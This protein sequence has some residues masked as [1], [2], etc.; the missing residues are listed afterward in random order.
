M[1]SEGVAIVGLTGRFPGARTLEE[2]WANLRDGVESITHFS[3]EELAR[4]G[5]DPLLLDRPEYVKSKGVLA[6]IDLF[7]ARFFGFPP[8]EAEITDPQHRIFLE[9][10]WEALEQ[11]GYDPSCH[12]GVT[13]VY[14]GAGVNTYLL[15]SLLSGGAGTD[16]AHAF[17][18][19]IHNKADHL[20]TRVAYK[21]N[22]TGP[23]I[24]VQTACS[25]SLVA[26]A[27]ACQSLLT[28]QCDT[29]LAGGVCINVPQTRGYLYQEGGVASPDG[30]C[31]A[32]DE[33]AKGVVDGSGAGVVVLK[34]L[35]DALAAGDHIHAVIRGVAIN[36]DG[37]HKQG[38]TA[39]GLESQ[40]E[41]IAMAQAM[42]EVDPADI[43]YVEAHGTGT[44]LG[45]PIEIAA[46]IQAFSRS[47]AV[48]SGRCAVGSVKTNIGHLDAAAGVA[49]LI[50]TILALQKGAI[51]PTLH[52][53]RPNPL[54][55]FENSPFYVSSRLVPWNGDSAPRRA[56]VSSFG[57]GG[58][59]AHVVVEESPTPVP[60][61][62]GPDWHLLPI[63]A[64]TESALEKAAENLAAY[65]ARSTAPMADVAYT[66][67][68]G[69]TPHPYR[70]IVVCGDA[71]DAISALETLAPERVAS[72]HQEKIHR[73]IV[74]LFPGQGAQYPK[75]AAGLFL[76]QAAF[77]RELDRCSEMFEP[78]L[79]VRLRDLIFSSAPESL[80]RTDL[81]QP[82]LFAVAYSIANFWIHLGLKP[83]AMLGHSI[84]EYVA[85]CLSGVFT[86]EDAAAA[87]AFRGRVM[88]ATPEGAMLAVSLP[89]R[90]L[91]PM[92]TGA[93]SLAAI[94][95]ASQ[96]VVSG[97]L[98]AVA[99]LE[100][101]LSAARI[102][103]RR[104]SAAR[105]FHSS[106]TDTAADELGRR[107]ENV[108]L[109][110]PVIPFVSSL[111]GTWITAD[112]AVSPEYWARHLRHTVRFADGLNKILELPDALLIEAG[113]GATLKT[114]A[115]W[116]PSKTP[117]QIVITSLP[118][119]EA[120]GPD[121]PHFLR[122]VGE[123][124]LAG[125][126]VRWQALHDG[127]TRRRVPLPTYPFERRRYWID[128][129]VAALSVANGSRDLRNCFYV[130]VWKRS[131]RKVATISQAGRRWMVF[132]NGGFGD[133]IIRV[134]RNRGAQV[135]AIA[136]GDDWRPLL[137]AGDSDPEFMIHAWTND[138][139]PERAIDLG[140]HALLSFAQS[141]GTLRRSSRPLSITIVSSELFAVTRADRV[142][143]EKSTLLGPAKVIPLEY[144]N[145]RCRVIDVGSSQTASIIDAVI[146]ETA[147]PGTDAAVAWRAGERWT[148][149]FEAVAMDRVAAPPPL[150]KRQGVYLITGGFGGVGSEIAQYLARTCQARLVLLGRSYDVRHDS[151][152]A[153]VRRLEALGSEVL[154]LRADVA[155][156]ESMTRAFETT[157]LRFGS[158]DGVF[159]LAGVA[160][161]GMI[162]FRDAEAVSR[163]LT[164][165]IAGT[166]VIERLISLHGC[167]FLV[168]ASSLA[169]VAGRP[170]QVDYCA[171][172]A[173]LD[174]FAREHASQTGIHTVA[175][176]WCEWLGVGMA[177]R[178][179]F[180]VAPP[181][182]GADHPLLGARRIRP[183]GAEIYT[184]RFRVDTHW[185][186]DE[187]RLVGMAVIP[188]TSYI[189]MARAALADR[190]GGRCI[191]I[192][193]LYFLAPLHVRNHESREVR[194]CLSPAADGY[195]FFVESDA[196]APDSDGISV[197]YASGSA[198]I[199]DI[200]P[201]GNIDL[202]ELM[203]RCPRREVPRDEDR[204]EDLGPRWQNVVASY[205]GRDEVLVQLELAEAFAGD[206]DRIHYH[207]ALMD[208]ATGRA[209]EHLVEGAFLPISYRRIRIFRPT[210]SRIFSHAQYLRDRDPSGE[211][212]NYDTLVVDEAGCPLVEIQGFTQKRINQAGPA[213]KAF[214]SRRTERTVNSAP[215]TLA[216]ADYTMSA[217]E[218][219]ET[220]ERILAS[221]IGPQV[222]VSMQPLHAE[223]YPPAAAVQQRVLGAAIRARPAQLHPRPELETPFVEPQTDL[224][225]T[226]AVAW[227]E[228]LG[229]KSIGAHDN[230]FALGGDSVQAIQIIALL[231]RGGLRVSPQQ[232][233]Q[234]QTIAALGAALDGD[235]TIEPPILIEMPGPAD[236]SPLVD[237][238]QNELERLSALIDEADREQS[239]ATPPV[240]SSR[241]IASRPLAFSL[242]YFADEHPAAAGAKYRLYLEGAQFADR[243]GFEAVWTPERH[244]HSKGGLYPNPSVL[245]AALAATT[246]QIQLRAGSVVLP[247][248]SA[249]RVAEEWA[250]V[251]NLSS[252]RAGLSVA[253]GWQPNDF[254]FFPGHYRDKRD[255]M[256]RGIADLQRL[257]RGESIPGQDGAGREI[258]VRVFPRPIQKELPLWLTCSGD[259]EMFRI[260]GQMGLNVLTAML[261]HSLEEAA[262]KI[263]LYRTARASSGHD[264]EAGVVTMMIHTFVGAGEKAVLDLV[265]RP[266]CDYLKSHVNLIGSGGASLGLEVTRDDMDKHLDDLAAFAFERYYRTASLIGDQQR[267][268]AMVERLRQAGVDEAA[269]LID[270]GVDAGAVLDSLNHLA[271]LK[272]RARSLVLGEAPNFAGD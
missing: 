241:P 87:V 224:E 130:P 232:F 262:E 271:Q 85:A 196:G 204:E 153:A 45:D 135:V 43:G 15:S 154:A 4:A 54:I 165:K 108:R 197:R 72:R 169:G 117:H 111:T 206:F 172:N 174:A 64:A 183:D 171:A 152:S 66:M 79:G 182:S 156:F 170:G 198:R 244:F 88:Q 109:N 12:D 65:V 122:A 78:H 218:G 225:H 120:P 199:L 113:P 10:C 212:L 192:S 260:A 68:V 227:R 8:R 215:A 147:Q 269:C 58:T 94:N 47:R 181:P 175:I 134:L 187:H 46:L 140:F 62:A 231:S 57:I 106:M 236:P 272:D 116:H 63:S 250:V 33:R 209:Q 50:K 20:T 240:I 41:V 51:P 103:V 242:F 48:R 105:A 148:Q 29:A 3:K 143:A 221:R 132:T 23:A 6:D 220:L 226:L 74:L 258:E 255:I 14:A 270:F 110:P 119:R 185:V 76:A 229:I 83:D 139:G 188:G 32:F 129:G 86:L 252:G 145:V 107:L 121:Y 61:S 127:E 56:G 193:D 163:V 1:A 118:S 96:C 248:H 210:T 55:D 93:L 22:L 42:A 158:I 265:R 92:L 141:L 239:P 35:G 124:W 217:A 200:A 100:E 21:L 233:F 159:H 216:A 191:E 102:A 17:Q 9:C 59:N 263:A 73:P 259:P 11:A 228:T 69:R 205:V 138:E 126:P 67:Q 144:D 189:E 230:F 36:N 223:L 266:L 40:A 146:E 264:P 234:H 247:L 214:A 164:P 53:E 201:P 84:G 115:R 243:H 203:A 268:M 213:I 160:S 98:V 253:S 162:Q 157:R 99:R 49:G 256:F 95:S 222:I 89:E 18:T 24:T 251:D 30:H 25:T 249:L 91:V 19:S 202:R 190:A 70:R 2:F 267:C 77:R 166:R 219:I 136:P 16:P 208:R 137:A 180:A 254:A 149:G 246:S 207:P 161:G 112:A 114:L 71:A 142:V 81:T 123:A 173:F 39:P 184:T 238:D 125:A 104:L 27:L 179:A 90:E 211:T 155:D 245:S 5:V 82:A 195:D 101:Q 131:N 128:S 235:G 186:L 80:N 52:F 34:R 133:T 44:P 13:A 75:M 176:D 26:V 60:S 150:L 261:T 177:G 151:C 97:S 194:L 37:S 168:L 167:R 28:Y 178:S 237:L 31:R 257:W 7:D 38:Y